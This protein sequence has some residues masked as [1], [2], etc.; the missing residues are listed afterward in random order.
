MNVP[1][2]HLIVGFLV[3]GAIASL[4]LV[5][6]LK[7]TAE[8]CED[9]SGFHPESGGDKASLAK[10]VKAKINARNFLAS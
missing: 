6:A 1:F 9:E 2:T 4:A 3:L 10:E 8:G 5:W 7:N